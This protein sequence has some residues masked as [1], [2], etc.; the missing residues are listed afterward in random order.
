MTSKRSGMTLIELVVALAITGIAIA[1]G[2]QAYATISDRRSI[3]SERADSIAHAFTVR[4]T[5]RRWLS[6]ARLTVEEDDVVFRGV[7]TDRRLGRD[8]PASADLVFLTSARSPVSNHG[9]VVHLFVARDSGG[10]LVADI[11]EWRGQRST[12]LQLDPRVVGL[13]IEFA[14][15]VNAR[16]EP[17]TSW[18]SATILPVAVR[19]H[20]LADRSTMLPPLLRIPLVI[21]LDGSG[22]AVAGAGA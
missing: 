1:S 17:T 8:E 2:Y 3:A 7:D 16:S 14:S 22:R 12:R 21:R 19:L 11:S 15:S 18:V 20:F 6:S 10:G 5:L 13:S 4:A 9:T